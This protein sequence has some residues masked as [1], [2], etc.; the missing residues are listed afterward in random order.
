MIIIKYIS[1]NHYFVPLNMM[2]PKDYSTVR[3]AEGASA[4]IVDVSR[5][6]KD[7]IGCHEHQEIASR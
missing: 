7:L 4:S 5:L 1:R 6:L 2:A 3:K